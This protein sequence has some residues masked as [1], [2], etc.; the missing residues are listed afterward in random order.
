M[1]RNVA[2]DECGDP[3]PTGRQHW[4]TG[5]GEPYPKKWAEHFEKM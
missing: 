2:C 4:V 1:G 5:A 3:L